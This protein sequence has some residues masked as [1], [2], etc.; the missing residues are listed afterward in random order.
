MQ[1]SSP[2]L[3]TLYNY[4]QQG[5]VQLTKFLSNNVD[6]AA[7]LADPPGAGK[8]PQA[9]LTAIELQA[10][11]VIV[12]CPASLRENWKREFVRWGQYDPKDIQI[13]K[14][15]KEPISTTARVV[16]ISYTM[17]IS[18]KVVPQY[19]KHSW[20]LLIADE[21]HYLKNPSSQMSRIVLV[22]I[23]N[24]CRYRLLMSGTPLP[25][26]RANEAWTTFSRLLSSEFGKWDEYADRFCIRC[27]TP[28]GIKFDRSKNL[29]ELQKIARENFMVRRSKE[30]VLGELPPLVRQNIFIDVT[31]KDLYDIESGL[32]IERIV[33]SIDQG[34][35]LESDHIS[36]ARQKLGKL[37]AYKALEY[38]L[39]LLDEV[40]QVVV[41]CHH[42]E[43]WEILKQGFEDKDVSVVGINGTM[44]ANERQASVDAFQQKKAQVFLASLRA[45]NVGLTLTTASTMVMVEY[46]WVPSTNEQAEG[47]I[48]RITQ[49]EIS[50]VH[51]L[52]VP[53]S[54]DE[55]V[56]AVVQRKQQ[57]IFEALS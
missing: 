2:G 54:L 11:R 52:V 15:G 57:K 25:N 1:N 48:Y 26:G 47:R 51:Y 30:E 14:S 23:W 19:E 20:D 4:Q 42:K 40:N 56:L 28:W 24:R 32:D 27:E 12:L 53:D 18:A 34:M 6:N 7:L 49:D 45:A 55:K 10:E 36:T 37:K 16:I 33:Q 31:P 5:I 29:G 22:V 17:A 44:S 41:F 3:P 50:R 43:P 8:T 21:S 39:N 46:D 35:P 13:L 38:V 9:I